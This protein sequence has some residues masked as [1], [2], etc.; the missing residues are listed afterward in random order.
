MLRET[1]LGNIVWLVCLVIC[2]KEC[3]ILSISKFKESY[4]DSIFWV[5][6]MFLMLIAEVIAFLIVL[7]KFLDWRDKKKEKKMT[8][9]DCDDY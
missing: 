7:C 4:K 9:E 5:S 6:I 1:L 2:C 8:L 3:G